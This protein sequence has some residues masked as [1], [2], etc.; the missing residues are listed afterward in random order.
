MTSIL[1]T[2]QTA[3]NRVIV[4][5]SVIR[6]VSV[7]TQGPGGSSSLRIGS[8]VWAATMNINWGNFD[9]IRVT[10]EA[11][12]TFTFTDVGDGRRVI[13]ELTQDAVGDH[14]VTWPANVRYSASL[15]M[16]SLS[17]SPTA[18]DRVGFIFNALSDTFDVMAVARGF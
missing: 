2:D 15:P 1:V 10:L 18:T 7:G 17:T 14:Q 9:L 4:E 6:I 11:D 3:I 16:I 12:T 13:L 8:A 5:D